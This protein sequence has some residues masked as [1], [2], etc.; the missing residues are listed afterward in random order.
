MD[1]NGCWLWTRPVLRSGYAMFFVNPAVRSRPAHRV[2]YE[3]LVGDIPDGNQI[4]HLCKVRRCVNPLHLEPVTQRENILRSDAFSAV[5]ARKTHCIH[6][7]PLSGFNLITDSNGW[8][9]CRKCRNVSRQR[10]YLT[11]KARK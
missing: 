8:R 4:D 11:R 5:N 7:H 1:G 2:A 10:Q 3:A 9:K 6:G